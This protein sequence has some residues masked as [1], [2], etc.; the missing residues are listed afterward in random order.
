M[1]ILGR[2]GSN[3]IADLALLLDEMAPEIVPLDASLR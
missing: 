2:F 1:V 3:A